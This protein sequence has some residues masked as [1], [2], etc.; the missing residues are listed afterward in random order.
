M[1]RLQR[2]HSTQW[3][4]GSLGSVSG[5]AQA[6]ARTQCTLGR[7]LFEVSVR[8]CTG[9]D[10]GSGRSVSR[11]AQSPGVTVAHS[12]TLAVGGQCRDVHSLQ[13]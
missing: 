7:Q 11:V 3:D 8:L 13:V 12:G 9:F 6:T 10:A 4:A 2:R 1:H 5:A